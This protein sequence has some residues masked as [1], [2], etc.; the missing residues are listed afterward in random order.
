MRSAIRFFSA[1][2]AMSA[3]TSGLSLLPPYFN[4]AL[5]FIG[6]VNDAQASGGGRSRRAPFRAAPGTE[7]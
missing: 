5:K 3:L 7:P 4:I 1:I 2:E 6:P